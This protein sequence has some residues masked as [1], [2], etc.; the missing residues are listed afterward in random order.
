MF[1]SVEFLLDVN[2]TFGFLSQK[3]GA[4]Q[5]VDPLT[6]RDPMVDL[7]EVFSSPEMQLVQYLSQDGTTFLSQSEMAKYLVNHLAEAG[8]FQSITL[9]M[10]QLDQGAQSHIQNFQAEILEGLKKYNAKHGS[11]PQSFSDEKLRKFYAQIK[12]KNES[13]QFQV[14]EKTAEFLLFLFKLRGMQGEAIDLCHN[15]DALVKNQESGRSS[16]IKNFYLSDS[17]LNLELKA[18]K[19][20]YKVLQEAVYPDDSASESLDHLTQMTKAY[21]KD[22]NA[23]HAL[24]FFEKGIQQRREQKAKNDERLIDLFDSTFG[25]N[26]EGVKPRISFEQFQ[27]RYLQTMLVKEKLHKEAAAVKLLDGILHRCD[28][29]EIDS[30]FVLQ[31]L[32][33]EEREILKQVANFNDTDYSVLYDL[34]SKCKDEKDVN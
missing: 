20:Y 24:R 26:E 27:S 5:F 14:G 9:T 10:L 32:L 34:Y 30:V 8:S 33:R 31:V 16:A 23:E 29:E 19:N 15:F 28:Q 4:R 3:I 7:I 18:N 25:L 22:G 1:G 2:A 6:K 21:F 17:L 11:L 12:V 13:E